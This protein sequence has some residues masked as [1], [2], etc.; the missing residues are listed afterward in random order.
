MLALSKWSFLLKHLSILYY[1]SEDS[2]SGNRYCG[3]VETSDPPSCAFHASQLTHSTSGAMTRSRYATT[4]VSRTFHNR[5][6]T[7]F[8][9]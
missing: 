6:L 5:L 1:T 8:K 7:L 2:V 9:R 4:R 3:G